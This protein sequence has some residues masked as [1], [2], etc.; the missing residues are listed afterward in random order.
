ML[1]II[2]L[3][4]GPRV[5]S[6]LWCFIAFKPY[7]KVVSGI[8]VHVDKLPMISYL[9]SGVTLWAEWKGKCC[10]WWNSNV[11]SSCQSKQW[12]WWPCWWRMTLLREVCIMEAGG[13]AQCRIY[14]G[15]TYFRDILGHKCTFIVGHLYHRKNVYMYN[16]CTIT[17]GH[18]SMQSSHY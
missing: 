7:S 4:S 11:K 14:S 5:P 1:L 3:K 10:D 18:K 2:S 6:N 12:P 15:C 8:W 13:R 16:N 9:W 17:F